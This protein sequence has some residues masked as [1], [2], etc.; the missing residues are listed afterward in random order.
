ME[1]PNQTHREN[2]AHHHNIDLN[3]RS[4]PELD[5]VAQ[6]AAELGNSRQMPLRPKD[7]ALLEGAD[8]FRFGPDDSRIGWSLGE[9]PL[10]I[11]VHGYSGRGIQLAKIARQIASKGFQCIFFDAGGH[12]DSRVEKIGFFTFMNDTRDIFR[13][14]DAP[15]YALIG[16]S[17]GVLGMMR[18]RKLFGLRAQKY[19]VICAP[20]FPYVPLDAMRLGGAP[21]QTIT[22]IKAI[23]SDQFQTSWSSLV[24]GISF[25]ADAGKPLLAV[26]DLQDEMV[27]HGDAEALRK[28]WPETTI[29]KTQGYGHNKILQAPETIN[30]VL[31]FLDP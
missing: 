29:V 25:E 13:H 19:G 4:A 5:L 1:T 15:V 9:G 31:D 26:Y 22:Y 30:A 21:E 7:Q 28:I 2:G 16:H 17:A 10:V 6:L 11:L 12:G 27:S 18:A 3:A 24:S 8:T 23:L 14:F 20:L